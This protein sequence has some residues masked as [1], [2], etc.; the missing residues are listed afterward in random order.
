[1]D[2]PD[3]THTEGASRPATS[4]VAD[5]LTNLSSLI[6]NE[7]NLA[8]AEVTENLTKA[9]TA[10]GLI[11][12]AIVIALVALNVLAGALVIAL[13]AAGLEGG[14]A[15]LLVGGVMAVIAGVLAAKGLNDLRA[16]SLAPTRTADDIKRSAQNIKES[17]NA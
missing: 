7:I 17:Y 9:V 16:S 15:A 10:V 13:T 8:R 2:S 6:R 3:R 4:V 12:G 5:I 14:W 1:M 11:V